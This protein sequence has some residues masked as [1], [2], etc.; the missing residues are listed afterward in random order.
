MACFPDCCFQRPECRRWEADKRCADAIARSPW[1]GCEDPLKL[2]VSLQSSS[3]QLEERSSAG[4]DIDE[5]RAAPD[6]DRTAWRDRR[7]CH[8][9]RP[10][11]ERR[12]IWFQ[13]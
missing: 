7:L 3:R 11:A 1:L 5:V 4:P 13:L 12:R 8:R 6:W 9:T 2:L 10:A